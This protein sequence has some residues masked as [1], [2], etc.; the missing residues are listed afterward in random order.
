MKLVKVKSVESRT[1]STGNVTQVRK[2]GRRAGKARRIRWLACVCV[3]EG[4]GGGGKIGGWMDRSIDP[5]A[6]SPPSTTPTPPPGADELKNLR[7][8]GD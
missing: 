6:A 2:E 1:G 4:K 3:R 7:P 8:L 5:S